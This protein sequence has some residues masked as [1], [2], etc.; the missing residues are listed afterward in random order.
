L[1]ENTNMKT[2]RLLAILLCTFMLLGL[3]ACSDSNDEAPVVPETPDTGIGEDYP[4]IPADEPEPEPEPEVEAVTGRYDLSIPSDQNGGNGTWWGWVS[5][6][7]DNIYNGTP[8]E[9]IQTARYLVIEFSGEADPDAMAGLVWQ[10]EANWGWNETSHFTLGEFIVNDNLIVM[11]VYDI[12]ENYTDFRHG[13]LGEGLIKII[14]RYGNER[15]EA[16][17][18]Y[19]EKLGITDIYLATGVNF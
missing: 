9:I 10:S 3:A 19:I 8:A 16:E 18:D 14:L 17:Y 11:P 12:M 2:K 13:E 15:D 4:T 7:T 6:G 5:D 1:E